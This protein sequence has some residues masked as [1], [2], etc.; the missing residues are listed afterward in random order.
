MGKQI[1]KKKKKKKKN[2]DRD[3]ISTIYIVC[4]DER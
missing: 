3:P 2:Y 4:I 1:Q